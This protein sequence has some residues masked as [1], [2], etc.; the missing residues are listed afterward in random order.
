ML[1]QRSVPT[2]TPIAKANC[3]G[4]GIAIPHEKRII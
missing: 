2:G 3:G 4:F 1:A